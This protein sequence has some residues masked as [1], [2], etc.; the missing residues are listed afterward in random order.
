[1]SIQLEGRQPVSKLG[2]SRRL[3]L[4]LAVDGSLSIRVPLT[5]HSACRTVEFKHLTGG[6]GAGQHA[7]LHGTVGNPKQYLPLVWSERQA[8][9][10]SVLELVVVEGEADTDAE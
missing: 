2:R 10:R 4:D 3:G 9:R 5:E 7:V 8:G 6:L 1:M